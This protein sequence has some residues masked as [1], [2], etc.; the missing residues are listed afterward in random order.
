MGNS[1]KSKLLKFELSH[2][3]SILMSRLSLKYNIFLFL[4]FSGEG[5]DSGGGREDGVQEGPEDVRYLPAQHLR[6][7]GQSEAG[8]CISEIL[9]QGLSQKNT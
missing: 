9:T 7:A 8:G 2:Y 3:L 5:E 1:F 4:F 6:P